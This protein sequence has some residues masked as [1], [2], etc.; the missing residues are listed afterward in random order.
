MPV[1]GLNLWCVDAAAADPAFAAHERR[2]L[3]IVP[4]MLRRSG[5]H[6]L[7]RKIHRRKTAERT[8]FDLQTHMKVVI[9]CRRISMQC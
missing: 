3:L 8:D 1:V 2:D 9:C 7:A 5:L 4:A 6:L